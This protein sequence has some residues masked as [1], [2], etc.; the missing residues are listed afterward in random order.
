MSY[1]KIEALSVVTTHDEKNL[2]AA[3]TH[4]RDLGTVKAF[5]CTK[6]LTESQL[7]RLPRGLRD[8]LVA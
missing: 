4:Y 5:R 1:W 2:R 7:L 8:S 6:A 3:W